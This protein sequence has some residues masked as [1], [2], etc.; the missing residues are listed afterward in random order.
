MRNLIEKAQKELTRRVLA[1]EYEV[2]S[3]RSSSSDSYVC[4]AV[5]KIDGYIFHYTIAE[6]FICDRSTIQISDDSQ[7]IIDHFLKKFNEKFN[8]DE[9]KAQR[10][11]ELKKQIKDLES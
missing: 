5:F 1:E 7:P 10:I 3:L 2:V 8:S 6:T 9:I 4:E 11:E